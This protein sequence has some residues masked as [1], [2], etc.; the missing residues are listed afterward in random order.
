VFV[1]GWTLEA[2]EA[3]CNANGDLSLEI[4][5]GLGALVDKSLLKQAE[6][7]TGEPRFMMLETIREYALERLAASEEIE[8]LQRRHANYFLALAEAAEPQLYG[9]D[10]VAWID[11]LELEHDNL[12]A[13]LAWSRSAENDAGIGLHLVG[14]L[15]WFW[16]LHSHFSEGRMWFDAM[17]DR[18]NVAVPAVRAKALQVAGALA[19]GQGEFARSIILN[20]ESLALYRG[21][22][23]V[24][25][26]ADALLWLGRARVWQGAYAQAR[27]LLAE[28]LALFQAQENTP[29]SMWAL[30][31]LGDLAFDNAE[32]TQARGYFQEALVIGSDL[33]DVFGIAWA[34]TN[35]GRIAHAL[36]DDIQA[37]NYYAQSLA[38][39]RELG[40]RRDIAHVYLELGRVARTQGQAAQA[41]EYYAGSLTLFGE[42]MDKQRIP[43]CLEGI[44]DLAS[45]A[46]QPVHAARL[47]GAAEA[48]RESA[49]VPLP[50]VHRA[51]YERARA[52]ARAALDE[53]AWRTAWA[54]GRALLMQQAIAYALS[55]GD[56]GAES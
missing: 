12:R 42:L 50:P 55:E 26:T 5:D 27:S 29:M 48:L 30:Q 34:L 52:A 46:R 2:A 7:A 39:F 56:G 18:P 45:E 47:F 54:E 1:G 23:D 51:D 44:A 53:L 31:S 16:Q 25:G 49:G 6:A 11:R 14:T 41:R 15:A 17:L 10:Q 38:S 28:S 4:L 40:H 8:A 33:G 21:L 36:G 35:L 43:E 20:E 19:V 13:V 24:V 32:V 22:D 37:Q 3:V 9:R